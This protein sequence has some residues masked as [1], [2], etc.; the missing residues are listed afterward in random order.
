MEQIGVWG[1][2][3]LTL[4]IFSYALGDNFLYRLAIYVFI[5]LVAGYVTVVTVDGVILPW[6]RAAVLT[7]DP[8]SR[9]AGIIPLAMGA[10]LLFKA[11]G[12]LGALANLSLG[13]IL[14]IGTAV[15]L[16]GAVSGTLLPLAGATASAVA[17]GVGEAGT[18]LN[19]I[20]ITTGVI[21]TL[22]YFQYAA[23]RIPGGTLTRRGVTT[24]ALA[25]VGQG[26][27]VIALGALY[28]GAILSGLVI[29]SERIAAL[30][31]PF[32]AGG[33]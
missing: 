17:S 29:F 22:V 11:T 31:T 27:I 4:M 16:V 21:C 15:A 5:G 30:L 3:I 10:L 19:G 26:V 9:V 7:G 23:R 8:V 12:R 32:I 28:G 25:A 1:G 20:L 24:R 2:F 18:L 14:G 13:Y 33:A 6:I